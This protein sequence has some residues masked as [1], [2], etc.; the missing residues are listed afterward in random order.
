MKRSQGE[1]SDKR[2]KYADVL[3]PGATV[4]QKLPP[5]ARD[6]ANKLPP[7]PAFESPS[8]DTL[9]QSG[10]A[11]GVLAALVLAQGCTQVRRVF[12]STSACYFFFLSDDIPTVIPNC[13]S[14]SLPMNF[15]LFLYS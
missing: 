9:T 14:H 5:W 7:R 1:V 3:S 13:H 8:S 10:I 11:L 6:L 12:V 4:K 2:V 15:C